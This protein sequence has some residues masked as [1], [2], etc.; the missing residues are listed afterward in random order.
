MD[1]LMSEV[2]N[3]RKGSGNVSD[4]ERRARAANVAMRLAALIGE[5]DN[6]DDDEG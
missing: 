4:E 5:G 3:A 6:S 1:W 2:R